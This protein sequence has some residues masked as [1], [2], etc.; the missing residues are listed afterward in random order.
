MVWMGEDWTLCWND[1]AE[2]EIS[3]GGTVDATSTCESGWGGD[4]TVD[5]FG[6]IS[7]SG[8]IE[9]IG[10]VTHP[11]DAPSEPVD[12]TGEFEDDGC[13]W[14]TWDQPISDGDYSY[15]VE[16]WLYNCD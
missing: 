11:G 8:N 9:G 13:F 5:F 4:R 2:V 10:T 12:A 7:L 3:D 15:E 14:I 1:S 6:D 16:A